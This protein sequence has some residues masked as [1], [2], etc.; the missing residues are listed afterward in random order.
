MESRTFLIFD[1]PVSESN[2][3]YQGLKREGIYV[4]L[5]GTKQIIPNSGFNKI[6]FVLHYLKF[7]WNII[8]ETTQNDILV[9]RLD[10]LAIMAWWLSKLTFKNRQILCINIML[11]ESH[12]LK[13]ILTRY[14]YKYPLNSKQF[15]ATI[16]SNYF[17][18]RISKY[19][20][21]DNSKEKLL[22]LNDDYGNISEL[23]CEFL[24]NGKTV[25]C[26]GNNGR[27]WNMVMEV[28]SKMPSVLFKVVMPQK[29]YKNF[30]GKTPTNVEL[31]TNL[32]SHEFFDLQRECSVTF[33]PLTTQAPAGLIVVFSA[34]LMKKV[35]VISDTICS[36]EYVENEVSGL[37]GSSVDCFV[38]LIHKGLGNLNLRKKL[39]T[40]ACLKIKKIGAPETYIKRLSSYIK[41]FSV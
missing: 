2:K 31:F 41:S 40:Q 4:C 25:F 16:T 18:D 23:E 7:C 17:G 11:K 1:W 21:L 10:M 27:D 8:N 37:L 5:R 20:Q 35:I 15:K 6:K 39:G 36:Q 24:D 34:A 33:L 38:E 13:G 12:G 28:A 22:L 32:S 26:G 9:F 29:T 14:A 19:L 3:I 30:I